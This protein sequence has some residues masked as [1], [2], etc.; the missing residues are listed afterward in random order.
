M[1]SW[2]NDPANRATLCALTA[3]VLV[4]GYYFSGYRL[5]GQ[6]FEICCRT[7]RKMYYL[8][9]HGKPCSHA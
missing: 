2:E 7:G 8:P 3:S 4:L 6:Y 1:I 5:K 9:L